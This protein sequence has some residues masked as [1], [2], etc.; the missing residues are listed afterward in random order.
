MSW[1]LNPWFQIGLGALLT[2]VAEILL[3]KGAVSA[4]PIAGLPDWAGAAALASG[5]TWLGIAAYIGSF[6]SW[7]RVLRVVPLNI[8][9][10]LVSVA[11]VLVPIGAAVVLDEHVSRWRWAGIALVLSGVLLLINVAARAEERA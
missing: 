1:F 5:W 2:S 8:A 10:S 7:L 11:Q 6:L 3:K 9:Y 4:D